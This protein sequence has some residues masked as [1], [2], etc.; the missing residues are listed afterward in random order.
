M[1]SPLARPVSERTGVTL[2]F[3]LSG[4]LLASF[5]SR[6]ADIRASL[7][8]TNGQLGLL[9]FAASAGSVSALPLAG[10]V[11]ER[12]GTAGA[13]RGASCASA[14]AMLVAGVGATVVDLAWLAAAGLFVYGVGFS[15][16]DVAMNVEA[17]EVERRAGRTLMPRFHA[18]WSV[19]SIAGSVVGIPFAAVPVPVVWHLALV[20]LVVVG[21][22]LRGSAA[23]PTAE[24]GAEDGAEDGAAPDVGAP[25]P[26]PVGVRG[27]SAWREPRTL[28]LGVM[29]LTFAAVE[30]SAN[31]WLTLA[32][33]DGYDTA[34]WVGVAGYAVFVCCMT[35]GRWFGGLALDRYGRVRTLW[36][37]AAAATAGLLLTVYAGHLGLALVGVAVWG[38]GASLGFPVGMSAAADDP[39]RAPARVAVFSTIGYTAFLTGPPVLG[40]LGDHVGTLR[41]LLVV[42]CLMLP[43][44]AAALAA[45]PAP[46]AAGRVRTAGEVTPR[47]DA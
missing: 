1:T 25:G 23:F 2:A 44:A 21:G 30:G 41:S 13:V 7:D 6:L 28:A 39:A 8:L 16:W 40:W 46:G 38:L 47:T 45:R 32:V 18:M 34:H 15:L 12:W 27:R 4:V 42:A 37:T 43:A 17:A 20:G 22:A 14:A 11:V 36:A 3:T 10:R 29:V 5:V 26:E 33:I 31:D 35:L 24:G 9:L 19:G